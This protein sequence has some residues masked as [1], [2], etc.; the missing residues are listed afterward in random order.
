M[1]KIGAK[2][3]EMRRRRNLGLREVAK[4]SGVS[5]STISLIEHDKM[6]PSVDTLSGILDALGTTLTGFFLE[7]QAKGS[8]APFY[9]ADDMVEIRRGADISYKM[10]GI[11]HPHRQIL[12]LHETYAAGADSGAD[13]VHPAEEAGMVLKGEI[14]LTVEGVRRILRQGEGYYFDSRLPHRFRNAAD[15]PCE[16]VSACTPPTY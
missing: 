8:P 7:A 15:Q 3:A 10:I 12:L 6:S 14:E 11:N 1:P 4:R 13:Y 2:L 5:H 9:G 16:I